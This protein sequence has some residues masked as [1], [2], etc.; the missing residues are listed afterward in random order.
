MNKRMNKRGEMG[1]GT[2]IIFIAMVLVAAVAA[3]VLISTGKEMSTYATGTG[4]AT[5]A[6]V[7]TGLNVMHVYGLRGAWAT[8]PV[9]NDVDVSG[10]LGTISA[11]TTSD[12]NTVTESWT[13]ACTAAG[14]PATFSVTGTISGLQVAVCT[15]ALS[16][17]SDG[18]EVAFTVTGP[19]V[20]AYTVGDTF[21]FDTHDSGNPTVI[22]SLYLK[23]KLQAGSDPIDLNQM[24][25]QISDGVRV[26]DFEYGGTTGLVDCPDSDLSLRYAVTELFDPNEHAAFPPV[27]SQGTLVKITFPDIDDTGGANLNLDT[28]QEVTV[29]L[30]PKHGVPTLVKFTLPS[31]YASENCVEIL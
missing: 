29:K 20:P 3:T 21:T 8:T 24:I 31:A 18:G 10:T 7:S 9:F 23:V 28:Q 12:A 27:L 30:I 1:I 19:V 4:K 22:T 2:L 13:L 5:R 14:P 16:Y 11:V 26:A 17:T 25:V 6:D 15:E